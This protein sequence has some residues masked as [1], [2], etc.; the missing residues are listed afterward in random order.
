LLDAEHDKSTREDSLREATE[1]IKQL[2]EDVDTV[3]KGWNNEK[4]ACQDLKREV[5]EAEMKLLKAETSYRD[6]ES[7]CAELKETKAALSEENDR[8]LLDIEQQK[9]KL[10]GQGAKVADLEKS[11]VNEKRLRDKAEGK[12]SEMKEKLMVD[13]TRWKIA[14]TNIDALKMAIANASEAID[15]V[16][17]CMDTK[18]SQPDSG[19]EDETSVIETPPQHDDDDDMDGGATQQDGDDLEDAGTPNPT[20]DQCTHKEGG[21]ISTEVGSQ[22]LAEG[23]NKSD[24]VG[25]GTK[26]EHDATDQQHSDFLTDQAGGGHTATDRKSESGTEQN[27]SKTC[28]VCLCY[29]VVCA[30]LHVWC[31]VSFLALPRTFVGL[32]CVPKQRTARL[33][34]AGY[35]V[36]FWL[37]GVRGWLDV[38]QCFGVAGVRA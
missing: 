10:E 12:V 5:K 1:Q 21:N 15:D 35:C 17:E 13:Q 37:G 2:Q 24:D 27:K 11:V 20:Q 18:Q 25:S 14:A 36:V 19:D 16:S 3:K 28:V 22:E 31:A 23:L 6:L 8:L 32:P 34:G 26:L 9:T 38:K 7:T 30:V 33:G 29:F 4:K